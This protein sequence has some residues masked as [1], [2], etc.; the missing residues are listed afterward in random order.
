MSENSTGCAAPGVCLSA[1]P[2]GLAR[3]RRRVV[4]VRDV[5]Q[6]GDFL[7]TSLLQCVAIRVSAAIVAASPGSHGPD[8]LPTPASVRQ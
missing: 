2:Q 4:L 8:R 3:E 6:P 5:I 1:N 7:Q